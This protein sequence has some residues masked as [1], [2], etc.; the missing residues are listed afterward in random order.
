MTRE[1]ALAAIRNDPWCLQ[2]VKDQ[3]K[4]ICLAAI[5]EYPDALYYVNDIDILTDL[6]IEDNNLFSYLDDEKKTKEL[7]KLLL[8]KE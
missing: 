5:K 6:L 7:K 4:E 1:K 3:D 8:E 2:Y